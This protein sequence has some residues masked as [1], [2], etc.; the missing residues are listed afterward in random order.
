MRSTYSGSK[1]HEERESEVE[2]F[3][4]NQG[5]TVREGENILILNENQEITRSG[6]PVIVPCSLSAYWGVK[7]NVEFEYGISFSNPALRSPQ[8][9]SFRAKLDFHSK[10]RCSS[11]SYRH[12]SIW[13][14]FFDLGF[15]FL[16]LGIIL[17][18]LDFKKWKKGWNFLHLKKILIKNLEIN[19]ESRYSTTRNMR[20][21]LTQSLV[22][23]YLVKRSN[24]YVPI[25]ITY[26]F[27]YI[28]APLFKPWRNQ[29]HKIWFSLNVNYFF[30]PH[31]Y[32]YELLP[33]PIKVFQFI[34]E[35]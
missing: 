1:F 6:S 3:V 13:N 23:F 21:V 22:I 12:L 35:I 5:V 16:V 25:G 27:L 32:F 34:S 30:L 24:R 10:S 8:T 20:L 11:L 29:L 7:L 33:L 14:I 19:N 4:R 28:V 26:C 9:G 15:L 31:R 2:K 18:N 17:P